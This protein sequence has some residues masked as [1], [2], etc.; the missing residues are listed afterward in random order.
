MHKANIS[1]AKSHLSQIVALVK[2]GESVTLLD[3]HRPVAV[4]RPLEFNGDQRESAWLEKLVARGVAKMP[5]AK[6]D[7]QEFTKR[8]WPA[9]STGPALSELLDQDRED[10]V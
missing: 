7:P 10:R 6:L 4:L 8:P 2:E 5:S 9:W 1:Y 3:R